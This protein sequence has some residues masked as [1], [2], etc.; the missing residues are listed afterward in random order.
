MKI[1]KY[2]QVAYIYGLIMDSISIPV[3]DSINT[4]ALQHQRVMVHEY[5]KMK[6]GRFTKHLK[7]LQAILTTYSEDIKLMPGASCC[8]NPNFL[9]RKF[10]IEDDYM[11]PE[12]NCGGSMQEVVAAAARTSWTVPTRT[13]PPPQPLSQ[14]RRQSL[15]PLLSPEQG[16]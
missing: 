8:P 16:K 7:H 12:D 11:T 13:A 15:P 5:A 9:T 10:V 1:I 14:R 6:P 2:N 4:Q 3:E